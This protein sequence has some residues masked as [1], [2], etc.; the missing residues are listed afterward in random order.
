MFQIGFGS[1]LSFQ[2]IWTFCGVKFL[3]FLSSNPKNNWH[4]TTIF[5]FFLIFWILFSCFSYQTSYLFKHLSTFIVTQLTNSSLLKR[6][7][8]W[9]FL[10]RFFFPFKRKLFSSSWLTLKFLF[11]S[12]SHWSV[13][14]AQSMAKLSIED[15]KRFFSASKSNW[16]SN[17][18]LSRSNYFLRFIFLVFFSSLIWFPINLNVA[19][20]PHDIPGPDSNTHKSRFFRQHF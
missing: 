18:K 6:I 11:A 13:S 1:V 8:H 7:L 10:P 20:R 9:I 15:N 4:F 16:I 3:Q 2:S 12:S 17:K 19:G 14:M 5:D